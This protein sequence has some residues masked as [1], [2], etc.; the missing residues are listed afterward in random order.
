MTHKEKRAD[1][2]KAFKIPAPVLGP[3]AKA[4][5]TSELEVANNWLKNFWLRVFT[6]RGRDIGK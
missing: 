1:I 6:S 2:V 4:P 5:T 3:I